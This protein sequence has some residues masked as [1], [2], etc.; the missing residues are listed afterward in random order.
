MKRRMPALAERFTRKDGTRPIVLGHRGARREIVENT[1][2]SFARALDLGADG[3]EL[4]VRLAE[5]GEVIVLHDRTLERVTSDRD[6]RSVESLTLRELRAV[7]LDGGYRVPLLGEVID[8]AAQRDALL[9]V[10]VKSDG[11]GLP[12]LVKAVASHA[13]SAGARGRV[14]LSS[15]HPLVVAALRVLAPETATCWLTHAGQWVARDAPGFRWLGASGVHPER[16]LASRARIE[17]YLGA[18]ALVNVWT[19]NDLEEAR[20]LSLLGVDGLITDV[21]GDLAALF[22]DPAECAA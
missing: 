20:R 13:R 15:F 14:L 1:I 12:A 17:R 5:G 11:R 6:A 21:P 10:E 3:V 22:P 19:V 8:W 9:N 4:D 7:E 2:E 18:G 16:A